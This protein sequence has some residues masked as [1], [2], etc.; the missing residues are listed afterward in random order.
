LIVPDPGRRVLNTL[1]RPISN[2][3]A[4]IVTII[5]MGL[6]P[7]LWA[8]WDT[9]LISEDLALPRTPQ[10][11]FLTL[12]SWN[13]VL[14]TGTP[15]NVAHT[16]I[17]TF[18]QQAG[19]QAI[20]FS[21]AVTQRLIMIL[22]MTLP[23]LG[24]YVLVRALFASRLSRVQWQTAA[25]VGASFYM[26]NLYI[27]HAWRGFNIGVLTAQTALPLLLTLLYL[28]F[29]GRIS[30]LRLAL[31]TVPVA[32][33]SS[34]VGV[35]PPL[36][37]VFV[38][39]IAAFALAYL[40]FSTSGRLSSRLVP[41]LRTVG[42]LGTA[43]I[44][45]NAFWIIP[46]VGQIQATTTGELTTS[47]ELASSWLGGLSA[48]TSFIKVLRFQGDWTWY[49]GWNEPYRP[50][51]GTY[52]DSATLAILSW[53]APVL[54]LVGIA[55]PKR[56]LR[57]FFGTT[58]LLALLL[59]MGTHPPM[60]QLYLW[61]VRNAPLF[62]IIRSPW[63]KF[64]LVT[65]LGFAVLGGLGAANITGWLRQA[66]ARSRIGRRLGNSASA[67]LALG[68][69]TI[70]LI[71]AYPV[72][73]GQMFPTATVR[74]HLP[75]NRMQIPDYV[76]EASRWLD[77]NARGGRVA[78]LPE[79]TVWADQNGFVGGS[80]ALTQIGV[81]PIVYPFQTVSG[82]LVSATNGLLNDIA[83][84]AIYRATTRRADEI[85][86]L[87]SVRYIN[88][89]T[90]IKYWL[91]AGDVD[92]ADWV[93]LRLGKQLGIHPEA[94][95]GAWEVYSVDNPLPKFYLASGLSIVAGGVEA[96]STMVGME[97]LANPALLF[98]EQQTPE[99]LSRATE[100]PLLQEILFFASGPEELALDLIPTEYRHP[101]PR[102]GIPVAFTIDETTEYRVWLRS[103][104]RNRFPSGD[105]AVDGRPFDLSS[106]GS[107]ATP[108]WIPLGTHLLGAG[109]HLLTGTLDSAPGEVV[110]VP[111]AIYS[112]L[113]D[114]VDQK[115][116][117]PGLRVVFLA[118]TEDPDVVARPPLDLSTEDPVQFQFGE[119]LAAIE[120]ADDGSGWHWLE[121][122]GKRAL[123]AV[124]ESASPVRTNLMLT[125]TSLGRARDFYVFP[126]DGPIPSNVPLLIQ[127]LPADR[128]TDILVKDVTI[129]PGESYL[130]LYTAHAPTA[131]GNVNRNFA[132][133][134]GS[135]LSGRLAFD[136]KFET[137]RDGAHRIEIRPYGLDTLPSAVT[138]NLDG[139]PLDLEE[140]DLLGEPT[141]IATVPLA[142]GS[143][144][145]T[146][147]QAGSE[148]YAIRVISGSDTDARAPDGQVSPTGE[149][150]TSYDLE[151]SADNPTIMIFGE[152]FDPRWVAAST[153]GPLE[154][155][156]V[157]GFANAYSIPA[158]EQAIS[159]SFGPQ[160][161]FVGGAIVSV[162]VLAFAVLVV[163]GIA[164]RDRVSRSE[165]DP[166]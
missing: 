161:L 163:V 55:G 75:P 64:A 95:F 124:N 10:Q 96:F 65:S 23:G 164:W 112:S 152:S 118:S 43:S 143:H 107:S 102:S 16:A 151:I 14:N 79:T 22:W 148:N 117:D 77:E 35:N 82:S 134:D 88:H 62:W 123:I 104:N 47:G 73:T 165:P 74:E 20:G 91:Y 135:L 86:K 132:V 30:S 113:V 115:L 46:F 21:P 111:E 53:V 92:S 31:Y 84:E 34:G 38:A 99:S 19:L 4:A 11:F 114:R 146:V 72:T 137:P 108:F 119:H 153:S 128:E 39:A 25:A 40:L 52:E 154:H 18:A 63:F 42:I 58:A 2:G 94:T 116:L 145:I 98:S 36:V 61:L 130:M 105:L 7:A 66:S 33:W 54:A 29:K 162:T 110:L 15:Y 13:P 85:L 158:G 100:S 56:R 133:L 45:I 97:L 8:P 139:I 142:T 140:R 90:G 150:P 87:M 122:D 70:N 76:A 3:R 57:L 149:S 69:V 59:S 106:T 49:Q 17:L 1:A 141:F 144:T 51:A 147:Q 71:Y 93:R 138:A 131:V 157:N 12:H 103:P 120:I 41:V 68:L 109:S 9:I 156:R 81:T 48:N 127:R 37:L 24:V 89:E 27:E 121:P 60:N 32:L 101:V 6:I 5:L 160:R 159:L 28:G 129:P 83:Y 78:A 80:P 136:L 50:Y 26:F 125:V 126:Y 67:F 155:Y 166:H 44:L